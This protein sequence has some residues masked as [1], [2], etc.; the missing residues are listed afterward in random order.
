MRVNDNEHY[1][2]KFYYPGKFIFQGNSEDTTKLRTSWC[3]TWQ[4]NTDCRRRNFF[5]SNSIKSKYT[6]QEICQQHENFSTFFVVNIKW[7]PESFGD[8]HVLA[9]FSKLQ[10]ISDWR[11][12][13][14]WHAAGYQEVINLSDSVSSTICCKQTTTKQS[15]MTTES[16][17]KAINI[18]K[19]PWCN[20]RKLK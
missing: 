20:I 15:V 11:R 17:I 19:F 8:L 3:Q 12:V 1:Q 13:L 7:K 9:K 16:V 18:N 4:R 5:F 14:T 6:N 2:S 10:Q